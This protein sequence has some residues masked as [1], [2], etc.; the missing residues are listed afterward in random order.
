MSSVLKKAFVVK[1]RR[2]KSISR[3][4][5]L[6]L[7]Y[8]VFEEGRAARGIIAARSFLAREAFEKRDIK[9]RSTNHRENA[10]R[11]AKSDEDR[12]RQKT[13]RARESS[14]SRD[15]KHRFSSESGATVSSVWNTY[16][17][18]FF[19][20][21]K[22]KK[23]CVGNIKFIPRKT[24]TTSTL[25]RSIGKAKRIGHEYSVSPNACPG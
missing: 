8:L 5:G 20:V 19:S 12:E 24:A 7:E 21:P 18:L 17:F 23:G 1:A 4:R 3:R 15:L 22:T 14:A 13:L 6:R 2:R 16:V 25:W 11:E 9:K 10:T